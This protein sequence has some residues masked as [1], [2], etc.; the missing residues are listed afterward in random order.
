MVAH[1]ESG[2]WFNFGELSVLGVFFFT[3][4]QTGLKRQSREK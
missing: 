1:N 2:F 4:Q 3:Q